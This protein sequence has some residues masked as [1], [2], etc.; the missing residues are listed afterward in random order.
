MAEREV[1]KVTHYYANI[2]VAIIEVADA[3]KV[4]D[5]IHFQGATS[6]FEQDVSSMQIE[7]ERVEEAQPGQV[8]GLKV[9]QKVREGDK[10]LVVG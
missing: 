10:V 2:G 1:G 8:I 6:D 9:E 5:R 7:H 3:I 4:G